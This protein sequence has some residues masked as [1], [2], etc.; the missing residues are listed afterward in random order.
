MRK[1]CLKIHRW[2]G[3]ALGIFISIICFS[4]AVLVFQDEI[5]D[6]M[7]DKSKNAEMQQGFQHHDDPAI[8]HH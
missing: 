2:L 5:K 7:Q 4:G 3:L 1:I 6:A 8:S